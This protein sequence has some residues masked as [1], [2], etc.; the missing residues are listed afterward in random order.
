MARRSQ[1]DGTASFVVLAIIASLVLLYFLVTV[2]LTWSVYASFLCLAA[3]MAYVEL[4]KPPHVA[5]PT[6]EELI[7]ENKDVLALV[8]LL[9]DWKKPASRREVENL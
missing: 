6:T 5:Y 8:P 1:G 7:R 2:F 9:E 3:A 4:R